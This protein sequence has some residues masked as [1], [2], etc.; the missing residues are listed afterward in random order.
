MGGFEVAS[1]GA[2]ST[3]LTTSGSH[4]F[5]WDRCSG[6]P[7]GNF[8]C[9]ELGWFFGCNVWIELESVDHPSFTESHEHQLLVVWSRLGSRRDTKVSGWQFCWVQRCSDNESEKA[10]H[11]AS[12]IELSWQYS[13]LHCT[14][15]LGTLKSILLWSFLDAAI[16]IVIQF[17]EHFFQEVEK[18]H[19]D[20]TIPLALLTGTTYPQD[21]L[22]HDQWWFQLDRQRG[23]SKM[24]KLKYRISNIVIEMID[25]YIKILDAWNGFHFQK[26]CAIDLPCQGWW[27]KTL[28]LRPL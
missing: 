10:V 2:V 5:C 18:D 9:G 13:I 28:G 8:V 24:N 11:R 6:Y 21:N 3:H 26:L 23:D 12:Q 15:S 27:Y 17:D 20:A 25:D 14:R 22:Q 1:G 16:L 4:P 19:L 7:G